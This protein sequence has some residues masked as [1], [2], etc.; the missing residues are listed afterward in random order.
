MN[1]FDYHIVTFVNQFARRS[2]TFDFLVE[3]TTNNYLLRTGLLM[4]LF[5]WAWFEIDARTVDR[6]ATLVFGLIAASAAILFARVLAF[7]LP[8]RERPLRNVDLGFVLPLSGDR[9]GIMGWSSFPSDTAVLHFALAACIFA[10]LRSWG[11]FAFLHVCVAVGFGRVYM[12]FH[13]PTDVLA[14][15][16]IGIAFVSLVQIR[17]LKAAVTRLPMEWLERR[18]QAF[19]TSSFLALFLVATTFDPLLRIGQF[20][21]MATAGTVQ[22]LTRLF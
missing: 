9:V 2:W 6:R 8:F 15:A 16:V 22:H 19:Y 20:I 18:P 10:V 5:C 4:A 7:T 21:R 13:Y 17:P 14:G 3:L 11:I 12:G 1:A